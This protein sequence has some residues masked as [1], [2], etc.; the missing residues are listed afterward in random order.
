MGFIRKIIIWIIIL[1]IGYFVVMNV[2]WL[3]ILERIIF[4]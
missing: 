2:N 4:K 3:G 1:V